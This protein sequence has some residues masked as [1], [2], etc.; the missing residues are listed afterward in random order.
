MS[1]WRYIANFCICFFSST[2]KVAT[3]L[4]WSKCLTCCIKSQ[5][6]WWLFIQSSISCFSHMDDKTPRCLVTTI[7]LHLFILYR[8]WQK[9]DVFAF[10][11]KHFTFVTNEFWHFCIANNGNKYSSFLCI[12]FIYLWFFVNIFDF[13]VKDNNNVYCG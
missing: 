8:H 12:W 2:P 11:A 7:I 3:N 13:I 1:R 9:I 5:G 4:Y 6:S 10:Y